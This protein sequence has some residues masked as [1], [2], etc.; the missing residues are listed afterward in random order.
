MADIATTTNGGVPPNG[1][2][3]PLAGPG[4]NPLAGP[5]TDF[6]AVALGAGANLETLTAYFTDPLL[7]TGNLP[8]LAI[9]AFNNRALR[10]G[11]FV[12]SSLCQWIS[13]QL[14]VY[15]PDD[16]SQINWIT[17]YQNALAAFVAALIPA[18]PNLGAYLPLAGGTMV[19]N[20]AFQ[21]GIST[22]LANNTWYF[23][24]DTGG[25]ARGL[26]IRSSDNNIYINDGTAPYVIINGTPLTANNVYYMGRDT[27]ANPH[28]LIG[29][30]SDNA[31]H[32]GG[33]LP[34]FADVGTNGSVWSSGNVITGNN[35]AFYCRDSGGNARAVMVL[36]ANNVFQI[37]TGVI[38]D[39]HIYGGLGWIYLHSNVNPLGQLWVNGYT[40]MQA[41]GRAY[42][43][44][45][46]D[47]LTVYSDYGYYARTHYTVGS[48]RDWTCGCLNNGT[49]A[50]ADESAHAVRLNI[51]TDGAFLVYGHLY[52]YANLYV[53]GGEVV[54]NG[55]TVY[56]S[57]NVASGGASFGNASLW[58]IADVHI[59]G[60]Y[61]VNG[62]GYIYGDPG[63]GQ[64]G[65]TNTCWFAG[66]VLVNHG[67][68]V[69]DNIQINGNF[70]C[71]QQ[72]SCN[73]FYTNY[74]QS[75][76]N[77]NVA[78]NIYCH[79]IQ[80]YGDC[81]SETMFCNGEFQ[82]SGWNCQL[83][84]HNGTVNY[85]GLNG[86]CPTWWATR[87]GYQ[88]GGAYF[89]SQILSWPDNWYDWFAAFPGGCVVANNGNGFKPGGGMWAD[90]SERRLK[91]NI[92]DYDG[93]LDKIKQLRPRRFEFN[94][95]YGHVDDGR[96]YIGLVA[97]EVEEVMPELMA[98]PLPWVDPG[99]TTGEITEHLKTIEAT[100]I[101]YALINAVKTLAAKVEALEGRG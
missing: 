16:G 19:G 98:Q 61:Y 71:N 84:M 92:E 15:I 43:P 50:I 94:G 25:Q 38:T 74:L 99:S 66:N 91:K 44:S 80:S 76:G 26:I 63:S 35:Y 11:T 14:N 81:H 90:S 53:S 36:G 95:T 3:I 13:N 75:N 62:A 72:G 87:T 58:N 59:I 67:V 64:I 39:T 42:I 47:P 93:G 89:M 40:Y 6:K 51:G 97:D 52:A 5:G 86:N 88:W 55:L 23:A 32:I 27:G 9:S 29:L 8:G 20:I 22:V 21:P 57:I 96:P 30:L 45:G 101:V 60:G 82:M 46:N 18:G 77:L 48:T 54:Y 31:V 83:E 2:M 49:F 37:G 65:F 10:Q 79:Y 41:G 7:Q 70:N 4:V 100:P 24:K 68:T 1:H 33:N 12:A 78:N 69:N 85:Q 28:G 34:V 56:G 73:T 17:E